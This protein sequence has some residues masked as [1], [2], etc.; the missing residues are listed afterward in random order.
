[1][2][3]QQPKTIHTSDFPGSL[4]LEGDFKASN[5]IS[6]ADN[7]EIMEFQARN[8]REM[9]EQFRPY[10]EALIKELSELNRIHSEAFPYVNRA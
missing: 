6:L 10:H 2:Q 8:I 1:M 3:L 7:A 5:E 9:A 4:K